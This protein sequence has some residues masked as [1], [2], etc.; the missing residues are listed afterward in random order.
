LT[1]YR[2]F[3]GFPRAIST[4]FFARTGLTF[5]GRLKEQRLGLA[6]AEI[7]AFTIRGA[8]ISAVAYEC[9]FNDFSHFNRLFKAK[10]GCTPRQVEWVTVTVTEGA[11]IAGDD[12][13]AGSHH[14]GRNP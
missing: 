1:T 14:G 3:S 11:A 13:I 12:R 4:F 6:L 5:R 9:G 8:S 7:R 10:F 2:A